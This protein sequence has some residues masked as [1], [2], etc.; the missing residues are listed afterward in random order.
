[1]QL[2]LLTLL[3]ALHFALLTPDSVGLS[4]LFATYLVFLQIGLAVIKAILAVTL[5]ANR[6]I[7]ATEKVANLASVM[8][9]VAED[10]GYGCQMT[11][12]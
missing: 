9:A 10:P 2:L 7:L 4:N 5:H 3:E 1:M 11:R 6:L 12:W 8:D